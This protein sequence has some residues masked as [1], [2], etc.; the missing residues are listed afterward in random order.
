MPLQ[1]FTS[2]IEFT[3]AIDF[4]LTMHHIRVFDSI[5]A[6]VRNIRIDVGQI[7]F[8]DDIGSEIWDLLD[9]LPSRFTHLE[10]VKFH[11]LEIK[12]SGAAHC[13]TLPEKTSALQ[14][15]MPNLVSNGLL[16]VT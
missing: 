9:Q 5:S 8:F 6:T 15:H 16:Y 2:L 7:V 4:R 1:H 12:F 3:L 10:S 13:L 11:H 14:E